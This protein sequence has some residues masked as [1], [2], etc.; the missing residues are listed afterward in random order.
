MTKLTVIIATAVALLAT[1]LSP[2]YAQPYSLQSQTDWFVNDDP[3]LFGPQEAWYSGDSGHG[4]GNNN[5]VY[6]YGISGETSADNW[7]HWYMGNRVGR[8]EIQVYVPSNQAK[9]TVYYN[10]YIGNTRSKV[11]VEQKNNPGWHSLGRYNTNGADVTIAVFDNDVEQHYERDTYTWSSIGIDAVAMRCVANCSEEESGGTSP[12]RSV[13]ATP[14]GT[15]QIRVT[16]SAP[17]NSGS[18]P[19]SGYEL[20]YSRPTLRNHPLYSDRG[21]YNSGPVNRQRER[22]IA[23]HRSLPSSSYVHSQSSSYQ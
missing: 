10:I 23:H 13:V 15:N 22:E 20:V 12:P 2:A 19:I 16:W 3:Y 17:A 6:T 21:P 11:R 4:Y 14:H 18:S 7:V 9:A 1:V 5:F 8:Q